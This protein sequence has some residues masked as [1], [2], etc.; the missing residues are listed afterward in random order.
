VEI[1]QNGLNLM[2][3][4]ALCIPGDETFGRNH[5]GVELPH[6][7]LAFATSLMPHEAIDQHKGDL[8]PIPRS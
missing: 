4:S 5:V 7:D 6:G 8:A 1:K 2:E 3:L